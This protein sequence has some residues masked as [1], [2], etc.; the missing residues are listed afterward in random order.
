MQ[1]MLSAAWPKFF[2]DQKS[3]S[4][5]MYFCVSSRSLL[6]AALFSVW[7]KRPPCCLWAL[8][9][10]LCQTEAFKT[11]AIFAALD[12]WNFKGSPNCMDNYLKL[13]VPLQSS[14]ANFSGRFAGKP[15]LR[16]LP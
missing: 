1:T 13:G 8:P 4:V 10:A 16:H 6:T 11:I 3:F 14:E 12:V 15:L 7:Q 5:W 9:V 2:A